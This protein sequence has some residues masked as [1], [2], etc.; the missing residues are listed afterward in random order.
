MKEKVI[1]CQGEGNNVKE[2]GNN[3]PQSV[4]ASE[5]EGNND[6]SRYLILDLEEG[7]VVTRF[8]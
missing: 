7:E 4:T 5:E 8:T 3:V 6:C 2:E 1:T